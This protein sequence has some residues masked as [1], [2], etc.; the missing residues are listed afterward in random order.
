MNEKAET[1]NNNKQDMPKT[2]LSKQRTLSTVGT[3]KRFWAKCLRN[4]QKVCPGLC[5]MLPQSVPKISCSQEWM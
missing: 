5:S 1:H 2:L 3:E 4:Y